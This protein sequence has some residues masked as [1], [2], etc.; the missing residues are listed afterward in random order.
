MAKLF[1]QEWAIPDFPWDGSNIDQD[2]AWDIIK[3]APMILCRGLNKAQAAAGRALFQGYAH[4]VEIYRE[5]DMTEE[6]WDSAQPPSAPPQNL[7]GSDPVRPGREPLSG[8]AIFGLVVL[9]VIV[10]VLILSVF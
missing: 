7:P 9:G 3:T 6:F 5:R 8:G 2:K 4:L 1:S 10:G